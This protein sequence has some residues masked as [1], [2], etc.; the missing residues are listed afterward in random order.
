[1]KLTFAIVA[2]LAPAT[3]SNSSSSSGRSLIADGGV[4]DATT[5]DATADCPWVCLDDARPLSGPCYV[6]P[7]A[8]PAGNCAGTACM[9]VST[10][11]PCTDPN[12][13]PPIT[14][15]RCQC[16][17]GSWSCSVQSMSKTACPTNDM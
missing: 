3:C 8:L 9:M 17:S 2:I 10:G 12:A 15:W 11:V 14:N 6:D 5:G 16:A 7:S 4:S 13:L 1:M